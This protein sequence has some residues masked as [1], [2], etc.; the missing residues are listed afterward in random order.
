MDRHTDGRTSRQTERCVE[1]LFQTEPEFKLKISFFKKISAIFICLVG[2]TFEAPWRYERRYDTDDY[3]YRH[4]SERWPENSY[5]SYK[6]NK[7]YY[8]NYRGTPRN[9]VTKEGMQ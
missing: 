2:P 4:W 1:A 6:S 8:Y 3:G 5:E 7:W 9:E